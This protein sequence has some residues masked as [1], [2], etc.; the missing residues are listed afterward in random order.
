MQGPVYWELLP[1][2]TTINSDLY[3]SQL[4]RANTAAQV[5]T[6]QGR[7]KGRVV[8]LQDNARPHTSFQTTDHI[9]KELG[10]DLLP[11]PSYSPDISPSDYHVFLAL[12]NFFRGRQF[13]NDEELENTVWAFIASKLGTDFFKRGIRK[14]PKRWRIVVLQQGEYIID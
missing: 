4:D 1:R 10:W 13:Q 2:A 3:C 8:F 9:K 11:H 7:R 5:M 14:L 12:K 6:V